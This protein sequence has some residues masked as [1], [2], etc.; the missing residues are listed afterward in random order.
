MQDILSLTSP[1]PDQTCA[2]ILKTN[3]QS[4]ANGLVLTPAQAMEIAKTH[5]RSLRENRIVEVGC[6]GVT[7]LI[8]AFAASPYVDRNNYA[9][10]IDEMTEMF[11]YIKREVDI[12]INDDAVIEAMADFF[13]R[14][15]HGSLELFTARDADI[16]IGYIRETKGNWAQNPHYL[17]KEEVSYDSQPEYTSAHAN[18]F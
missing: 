17:L 7:K 16:L 10:V 18:D 3:A 1:C 15:S 6:G 14:A 8:D 12:E 11:Y 9:E 4:A 2:L 5:S 13:D